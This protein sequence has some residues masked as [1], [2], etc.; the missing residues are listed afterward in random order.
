MKGKEK[1]EEKG[2]KKKRSEIRGIREMREVN[3]RKAEKKGGEE[4]TEGLR[5]IF[6]KK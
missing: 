1:G 4:K 5:I 3:E 2:D 6:I